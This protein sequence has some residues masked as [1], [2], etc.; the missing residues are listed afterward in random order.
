MEATKHTRLIIIIGCIVTFIIVPSVTYYILT[1]KDTSGSTKNV[2]AKD[3]PDRSQSDISTAITNKVP[4]LMD[5]DGKPTF[6]ITKMERLQK[7]WYV[8]FLRTNDDTTNSNPFKA[9]VYDGG[10]KDGL[11]V[12]LGP[13]SAFPEDEALKLGIP[14]EIVKELNK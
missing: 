14:S 11:S 7:A 3:L 1:P 2:P 5:N 12:L 9:L 4:E 6:T 10:S 13:G 8:I